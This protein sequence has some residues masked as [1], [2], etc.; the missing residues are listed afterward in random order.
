MHSSPTPLEQ[1][2]AALIAALHNSQQLVDVP[3]IMACVQAARG[4]G[5]TALGI[6]LLD[7]WAAREPLNF[8]A[9][10]G[11]AQLRY[12]SGLPTATRF[13]KLRAKD[14]PSQLRLTAATASALAG[15][16]Y[17]DKAMAVLETAL[18]AQPDWIDGHKSLATLRRIMGEAAD[19]CSQ[20]FASACTAQPL[21]LKL[22]LAWFQSEAQAKEWGK[23]RQI[24]AEGEQLLGVHTGL[25]LAKLFIAAETQDVTLADAL[26]TET[27]ALTD[28]GLEMSRIRY[29]LR[30]RRLEWAEQAVHR[31][32]NTAP[33]QAWPYLS[34]IW[35]IQ[36]DERAMWLDAPNET[37]K[38]FDLD[39]APAEL[40]EL[41]VLLRGLHTAHAPYLEQSVRGGTQTDRPLF[42]RQETIIQSLKQNIL[43]VVADYIA[44]LPPPDPR[45][46]LLGQPRDRDIL[47]SG[48]WSVRLTDAGFHVAHTHPMG[49]ISSS[50]YV[51][52]PAL[53][54][55]G[56]PPAGWISFGTPPP[57]LGL[58]LAP[59]KRI[60]PKAGRLVLFPSTMWHS[61]EPF[62]AGE[63]LVI[64][65]DVARP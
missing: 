61:T 7:A 43:A 34:L 52:L 24:I 8:T 21:N 33:A 56:A 3:A 13:Q 38:A 14:K 12:E 36:G 58:N 47:F 27:A 28:P 46:P 57:E 50:F 54:A 23:A 64:A 11:Q 53:E 16:G 10:F 37:I 18:A 63:R 15:E 30:Q 9:A 20:C 22:R 1:R 39:I 4:A 35:R 49:W 26:F 45:H 48:S 25:T 29:G 17:A 44:A 55:L 41:A 40:A 60:M 42:F 62:N 6:A 65:F 5:H 19:Q 59:Y 51:S 2:I 31:L 32:M